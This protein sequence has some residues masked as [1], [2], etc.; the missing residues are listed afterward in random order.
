LRVNLC[1]SCDFSVF[2]VTGRDGRGEPMTFRAADF[3]AVAA[4]NVFFFGLFAMRVPL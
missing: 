2:G 4:R 1:F 3:T